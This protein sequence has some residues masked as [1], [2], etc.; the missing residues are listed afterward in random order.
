MNMFP[1]NFLDLLIPYWEVISIPTKNAWVKI[2]TLRLIM[3]NLVTI[4][5]LYMFI[6]WLIIMIIQI[7]KICSNINSLNNFITILIILKW[8]NI[9]IIV[10]ILIMN[11]ILYMFLTNSLKIYLLIIIKKK[12]TYKANMFAIIKN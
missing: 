2:K 10:T 9:C 6:I 5:S 12:S 1:S 11:N 3:A 8:T 4:F 7:C